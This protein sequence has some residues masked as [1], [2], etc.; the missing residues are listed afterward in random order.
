VRLFLTAVFFAF[1]SAIWAGISTEIHR[2]IDIS[3]RQGHL[4]KLKSLSFISFK[5]CKASNV[6][7]NAI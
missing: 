1:L 6:F 2:H 3:S 7:E 4:D 5:V